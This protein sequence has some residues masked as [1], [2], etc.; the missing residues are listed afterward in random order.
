MHFNCR[1]PAF[2]NE[3]PFKTRTLFLSDN[4]Q[5]FLHI[6]LFPSLRIGYTGDFMKKRLFSFLAL[7]FLC[8]LLVYLP[9]LF[10]A[11][12]GFP[13]PPTPERILLRVVL[14]TDNSDS[15][16]SLY[17]AL[18]DFH[19]Q[20]SS[21]HLR[22]TRAG[23]EQLLSLSAP[24]PDVYIFP[25]DTLP[26][27]SPLLRSFH[28]SLSQRFVPAKG[29]PL[30]CAVSRTSLFPDAALNLIAFLCPSV[31]PCTTSALGVQ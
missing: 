1:I 25:E 12:Q 30:L 24:L 26:P 2:F 22:I 8:F 3:N 13:L 4:F 5:S 17:D 31:S 27:L 15:A 10:T 21:I 7:A 9:Q 6:L 11:V 14:C 16:S 20:N 29:T 28:D 18:K 19:K 23:M